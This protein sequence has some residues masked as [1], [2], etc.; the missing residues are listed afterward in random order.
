MKYKNLFFIIAL[1]IIL[2]G[3]F[4]VRLYRFSNPI[5]DWHSWRQADTSAVS[6]NFIE[7][8]FDILHP[9]Y[10]DISNVQ[11]G[12]DNP[13]GY[14]FVEFPIYNIFQAGGYDSFHI[15]TLEEWGRIITIIS[16]CL[17]VLFLFLIGKRYGNKWIGILAAFF[18]AFL[19]FSI[20]YGRTVLPD[21]SMAMT[22]LG[23]IYFFGKYLDA[24]KKLENKNY[25]LRKYI[26][27][28][29]SLL[30]TAVSLLLKPYALFFTLPF[31]VLAFEKYRFA[32]LK[33]W[34]LWVFL[35][36]TIVP[37]AAWRIWIM[38]YPE[39]I[40]VSAWLFNGG[41]IRFKGAYF[42][43]IFGERISKLILGYVGI[44]FVILGLFKIDKE[45][46][47]PFFLSFLISSLLYL[48]VIARGNVQHDYYQILIIPTVALFVA[49]G[50]FM[51][52]QFAGKLNKIVATLSF[53]FLLFLTLSLSWYYVRDYFNI[54]NIAIVEAGEKA[55]QILPKDAKVIAPYDGDTTLLYYI[56]RKGWPS[57]EHS[58]QDL[59]KMGATDMVFVNPDSQTIQNLSQQYKVIA[60]SSA[61]IIL[62]L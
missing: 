3:A 54:N 58:A 16:S 17:T 46:H 33:K 22:I 44:A 9:Q 37:L 50:V 7:H 48:V 11:S 21:P 60:S 6:K 10:F 24:D 15:F 23:G 14:R 39:G 28:V 52:Y 42:Y 59:Q 1:C 51:M 61:Y 13:H 55:D 30:F 53:A 19:P 38:Q 20:Y 56:N 49:R 45:K 57:F 4:V 36:L 26:W 31:L 32:F 40:P 5:A 8:G 35:I 29:I 25:E 27:F 12:L 2:V 62:K 43:W 47:Y 18:F 34:Q 41:D